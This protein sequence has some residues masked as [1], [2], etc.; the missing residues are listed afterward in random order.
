MARG[1]VSFFPVN[2]SSRPPNKF[3]NNDWAIISKFCVLCSPGKRTQQELKNYI[4]RLSNIVRISNEHT[5]KR[6]F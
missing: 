4:F 3:H 1:F 2:K 6:P 5:G